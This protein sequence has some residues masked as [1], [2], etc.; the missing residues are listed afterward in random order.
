VHA[1]VEVAFGHLQVA[2]ELMESQFQPR[3]LLPQGS[4][5]GRDEQRLTGSRNVYHPLEPLFFR[6]ISCRRPAVGTA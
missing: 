3:L 5:T 2:F 6:Q 1:G 4:I